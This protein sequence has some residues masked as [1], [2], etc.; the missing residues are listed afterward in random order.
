MCLIIKKPPGRQIAA[1]FLENAWRHNHHGW[2]C[3]HLDAASGALVWERG[4]DLD[5]LIAH[6]ARLPLDTE[7]YL[8][9]RRA[10]HGDVNH[11]MAHPF[12]VLPGLLL[13]HNGSIDCLAPQD[14]E[15]SD[16]A[17]LA[18]LLRDM[19]SGLSAIQVSGLIRSQ[20]FRALT[21]PL[22]DGSMVLL[23]D[24]GGP[25][26]LGRGWYTVRIDEWSEAMDGIEVSNSHTWKPS[27]EALPAAASALSD[28]ERPVP[29]SAR[30]IHTAWAL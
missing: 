6:N 18:R 14:T 7:V 26:R 24:A 5:D 27:S 23:L 2:G 4:L 10:T 1:D 12:E 13:M 17:E 9:L 16:T 29:V 11:H 19:L 28:N 22:V 21:A 3:F 8:H 30:A 20:G 25:V 15:V